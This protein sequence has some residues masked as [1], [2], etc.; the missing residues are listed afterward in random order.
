ML[1]PKQEHHSKQKASQHGMS[2]LELLVVMA[3]FAVLASLSMPALSSRLKATDLTRNLHSLSDVLEQARS[4][5]LAQ[6][7]FVWVGLTQKEVEGVPSLVMTAVSSRSGQPTDLGARNYQPTMRPM[8]LKNLSMN[9]ESLSKLIGGE[10]VNATDLAESALT[11]RQ[12]L[13]GE[14]GE[15]AFTAI[16]FKPN[17]EIGLG[18]GILRY[19]GIGIT[20]GVVGPHSQEAGILIS[21][22]SG[23]ARILRP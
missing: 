10:Q 3:I 20:E 2:L 5:A 9:P 16:E 15:T 6:N 13:P 8:I 14:S 19:V 23:H 11:I 21:R 12:K 4:L 22:L 17:G 1:L 7:T 18:N